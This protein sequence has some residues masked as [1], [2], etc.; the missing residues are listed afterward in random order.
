MSIFENY[1]KYYDLLYKD[2]DYKNEA[3]YITQLLKKYKPSAK[4][5]LELGCGTGK[6]AKMFEENGF[7]VL[8]IDISETMIHKAMTL[9]NENLSF[10]LGDAKTYRI[11]TEFDSV[12]SLFHVASYQKT[13]DDLLNFF[14]TARDH[15]AKGGIFIFDSWYGPGVTTIKPKK[16]IKVIEDENITI[17]RCAFPII[18]PHINTVDVNYT[19]D[20]IDKLS[21]SEET[22]SETHSMRYLFPQ[23]IKE[24]LSQCAFELLHSEEW[25]TAN[26]PGNNSWSVCFIARAL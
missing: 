11:D 21:G 16:R 3:K 20:I 22:I 9:A 13:D 8:G 14:K 24:M 15:L 4:T 25:D 1:S 10:N 17:K 12:L 26:V 6:H 18:Y 23:E 2:K 5:I 7:R 19:I